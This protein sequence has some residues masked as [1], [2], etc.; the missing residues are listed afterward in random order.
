MKTIILLAVVFALPGC[1]TMSQGSR[2]VWSNLGNAALTAGSQILV[3]RYS[4]T[5]PKTKADG[6][7]K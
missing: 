5:A 2:T 7:A 1:V 6:Y 4:N 3:N